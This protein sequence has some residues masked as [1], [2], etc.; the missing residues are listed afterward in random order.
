MSLYSWTLP[1]FC[2]C[3]CCLPVRDALD[4][5][6]FIFVLLLANFFVV[7]CRSRWVL[8]SSPLFNRL[9]RMCVFVHEWR[10]EW[11][12]EFAINNNSFW[13]ISYLCAVE[14]FLISENQ[15]LTLIM[16]KI[17]WE[18]CRDDRIFC[19]REQITNFVAW[20]MFNEFQMIFFVLFIFGQNIFLSKVLKY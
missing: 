16:W 9:I 2:C 20:K 3:W 4:S 18:S 17:N 10:E 15:K 5:A 13:R 19:E 11:R 12:R 8:C 7:C 6:H 1:S 14:G